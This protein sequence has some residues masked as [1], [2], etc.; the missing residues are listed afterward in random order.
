[1]T[2]K[3]LSLA[4]AALFLTTLAYASNRP[5]RSG[6]RAGG[7]T[8]GGI[9][10]SVEGS[11]I[12]LAGGA[13]TIDA[14]GATVHGTIEAGMILFATLKTADVAPNAPLPAATIS[15][16]RIPDGTLFGPVQSVDVA[17]STLTVLGRTIH[18]DDDTSFGGLHKL[19]GAHSGLADILPNDLVNVTADERDGRLVASSIMVLGPAAP[20]VV[21]THGTVRSIAADSWVIARERDGEITVVVDAQTKIVGSP[22]EGDQVEVLYRVDSA[23]RL[24]AISIIRFERPEPPHVDVFRFSGRVESMETHAWVVAKADGEKVKL[25]IER[26]SKVDP[27]VRIGDEVEVLAQRNEDGTVTALAI[28]RKR[29]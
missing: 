1:M 5:M 28:V 29:F 21:S 7:A 11:L 16:M 24:V 26:I 13:I 27:G 9:V 10:S 3:P 19:R 25:I 12:H 17:N 20:D 22:K 18:V 23:N 2:R 15:V 14:S 6:A 4:L 8:A